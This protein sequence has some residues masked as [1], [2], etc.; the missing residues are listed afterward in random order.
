MI[1]IIILMVSIIATVVMRHF[2]FSLGEQF[3]V[4]IPLGIISGV[5][6]WWQEKGALNEEV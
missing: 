1:Q 4:T 6:V 2:N 5:I 3:M